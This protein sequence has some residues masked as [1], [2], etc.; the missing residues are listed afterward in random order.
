MTTRRA[1]APSVRPDMP[2]A[3]RPRP[4]VDAGRIPREA[5]GFAPAFET[6][7]RTC[8]TKRC[9]RG[10]LRAFGGAGLTRK[11]SS[12]RVATLQAPARRGAMNEKKHAAN[13]AGKRFRVLARH[14]RCKARCRAQ[15]TC[16]LPLRP[17]MCRPFYL[18]LALRLSSR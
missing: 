14:R 11:L 15:P 16:R 18:A 8:D 6:C 17:G 10:P 7:F 12:S 1:V 5:E 9:A 3:T 13:P 2:A 4:K